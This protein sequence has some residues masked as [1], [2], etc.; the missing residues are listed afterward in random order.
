MGEFTVDCPSTE[1]RI[2]V[3]Q[4]NLAEGR[5]GRFHIETSQAVRWTA[6][7]QVPD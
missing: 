5:K 1:V 7:I 6:D 3:N 2:N 4:L